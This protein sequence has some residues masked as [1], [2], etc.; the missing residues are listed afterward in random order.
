MNIWTDHLNW[1]FEMT[2]WTDHLNWPFELTI[3]TDHFL[4]LQVITIPV[5]MRTASPC[6]FYSY[7]ENQQDALFL[8]FI[9]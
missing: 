5:E 4:W 8:K 2:I 3:W 6:L 1:P 9:W 7:N